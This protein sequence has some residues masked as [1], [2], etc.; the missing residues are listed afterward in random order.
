M[1][2]VLDK[3]Q[4]H[5][6][7]QKV[8]GEKNIFS[9]FSEGFALFDNLQRD[10]VDDVVSD[11][12]ETKAR[13]K[14]TKVAQAA[15]KAEPAVADEGE[16]EMQIDTGGGPK[17]PE[18]VIFSN[19]KHGLDLLLDSDEDEAEQRERDAYIEDGM[20]EKDLDNWI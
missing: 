2:E 15:Q 17:A 18:A 4:S 14:R 5:E 19:I 9:L 16:D 6:K 13:K 11:D 7:G 3:A 12:E 8:T 1:T 20:I 10:I